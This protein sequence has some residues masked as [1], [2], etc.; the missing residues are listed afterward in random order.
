MPAP[1]AACSA[2]LKTLPS[3]SR[4]KMPCAE[5]EVNRQAAR[6]ET[7]ARIAARLNKQL[8]LEAVIQA[9]C[10]EAVD[11]FQMSQAT[12][13]LFDKKRDLLVYVGG[14]NIPAEYAAT[15]EPISRRR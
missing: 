4:P 5:A 7:L 2:P 9:V 6:A 14:V 15:M 10:Q 13:S 1:W 8:E 11:T 12:M 3:A